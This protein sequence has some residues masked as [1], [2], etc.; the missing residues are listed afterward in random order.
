[1]ITLDFIDG[2]ET[3]GMHTRQR[4]SAIDASVERRAK[5][6]RERITRM[7]EALAWVPCSVWHHEMRVVLFAYA[8]VK[9]RGWDWSRYIDIRTGAS[10]RKR[11]G[12]DERST[13]GLRSHFNKLKAKSPKVQ[14]C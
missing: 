14:F 9:A 5:R 13:A 11:R 3:G 1:M 8:E 7:E 6:S 4:N 10:R 12:L 2:H